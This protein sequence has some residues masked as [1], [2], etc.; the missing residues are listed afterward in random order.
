MSSKHKLIMPSDEEDAQIKAGI[1]AD[2]DTHELS[3]E[4]F[5]QLRPMRDRPLGS[6]TKVQLTVRFDADVIESFKSAGDGWQTRMNDAL[7]DWLKT[8]RA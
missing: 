4:D 3:A 2:P 5:K 8:H 6:G 7:R 1:A